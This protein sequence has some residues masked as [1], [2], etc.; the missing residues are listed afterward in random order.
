MPNGDEVGGIGVSGDDKR[1][2]ALI[3]LDYRN[4]PLEAVG[5][6]THYGPDGQ[7]AEVVL[8]DT[9]RGHVDIKKIKANDDLEIKRLQE[10]MVERI[11]LNVSAQGAFLVIKD[12]NG[13]DRIKIGVDANDRP[14]VNLIDGNGKTIARVPAE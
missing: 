5:F 12:R 14:S 4:T 2:H 7:Q 8:M 13:K 10:M 9:P 6:A 11:S 3:T 1:G